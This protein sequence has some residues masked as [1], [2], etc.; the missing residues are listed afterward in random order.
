MFCSAWTPDDRR[1]VCNDDSPFLFTIRPSDGGGRLPLTRNPFGG[2]DVAV[3]FSPDGSHLAF[4]RS[5]A[6]EQLALMVANADGS[7]ARRITPFGLLMNQVFQGANWSPD[8]KS[9]I[10]TQTDGHLIVISVDGTQARIISLQIGSR[11]YFA[12][13]PDFSPDGRHIV[14]SA[15][16]NPTSPQD[17]LYRADLD[18]THGVQL[19]NTPTAEVSPDWAIVRA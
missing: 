14:F 7:Q 2:S 12:F 8:G 17:D 19:T 5:R 10:S 6:D 3:G 11:D 4:E 18:G 13:H 1:I 16:T 9:L 15:Y